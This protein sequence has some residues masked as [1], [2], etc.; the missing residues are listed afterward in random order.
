MSNP[1]DILNEMK[2][3]A[4]GV[5]KQTV[6]KYIAIF[7]DQELMDELRDYTINEL[8]DTAIEA[9]TKAEKTSAFAKEESGEGL[10]SYTVYQIEINI[11]ALTKV[12]S[13]E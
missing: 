11:L 6:N 10:G 8:S 3:M 4:R 7:D 2:R 1:D 13:K 9:I 12:E 5:L